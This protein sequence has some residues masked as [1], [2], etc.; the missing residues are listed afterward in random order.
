MK[1]LFKNTWILLLLSNSIYSQTTLNYSVTPFLNNKRGA[2]S[3]TFDDNIKG[4]YNTALPVMNDAKYGF[5]GTFFTVTGWVPESGIGNWQY[6]KNEVAAKGH[7]V[8][9]HTVSHKNLTELTDQEMR[10]EIVNSDIAIETN[11]PA[12]KCVTLAWPFGVGGDNAKVVAETKKRYIGARNAWGAEWTNGDPHD[13][14]IK[15]LNYNMNVLALGINSTVTLEK[16]STYI[17]GSLQSKWLVFLYHGVEEGEYDGPGRENF[18][19]QMDVINSKKD[20]L[21]VA[22]FGE[23]MRYNAEKFSQNL[24][25]VSESNLQWVLNLTD[26]LSDNQVYN[27]PLTLK[28]QAPTWKVDSVIQGGKKVAFTITSGFVYLNA[29]PDAG[30]I[31]FYKSALTRVDEYN[32]KEG[33]IYIFPNPAKNEL[34]IEGNISENSG[35]EIISVKGKIV[36]AGLINANKI[37]VDLLK[38]GQYLVKIKTAI[39]PQVRPFVKE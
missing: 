25:V 38:S 37:S 8:A 4:Q 3:L 11:I 29:V 20:L 22:P 32:S 35:Y 2:V 21:W 31:V 36:Q 23:V 18:I 10:D 30:Q 26:T 9:S 19:K 5:K 1:N 28:I 33:L 27:H 17:N 39:G 24:K 34:N 6:L 12:V 14:W 15:S 13:A 16:Y 7:E